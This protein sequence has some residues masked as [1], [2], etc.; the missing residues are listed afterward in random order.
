MTITFENNNDVI[1]YALEKVISFARRTQYVFVAQCVRWLA[2]IIGLEQGL[3]IPIDHQR[4][5]YEKSVQQESSEAPDIRITD[6]EQ[7]R[8]GKRREKIAE[9]EL[10]R[11]DKLLEECEESLRDSPEN[12]TLFIHP[13]RISRVH[14]TLS[15]VSDLEQEAA[16]SRNFQVDPR[17]P[18]QSP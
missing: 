7:Y 18:S 14:N 1:V 3:V 10:D 11:Q 2:F 9:A 5:R 16:A 13:D 4:A 6:S 15:C 8:Q 17:L 12:D